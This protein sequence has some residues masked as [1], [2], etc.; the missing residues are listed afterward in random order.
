VFSARDLWVGC[1]FLFF[2]WVVGGGFFGY[3]CLANPFGRFGSF[4]RSPYLLGRE[5][6]G[7]SGRIDFVVMCVRSEGVK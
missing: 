1:C 2:C 7:R 3:F 4:Y 5:G 6:M